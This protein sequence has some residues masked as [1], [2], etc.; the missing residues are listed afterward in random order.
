[1]EDRKD[2]LGNLINGQDKDVKGARYR[3]GSECLRGLEK[4]MKMPEDLNKGQVKKSLDQD[5]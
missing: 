3:I 4:M 1:M 5:I 2:S